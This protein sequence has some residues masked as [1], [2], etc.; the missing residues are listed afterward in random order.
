VVALVFIGP[1]VAFDRAKTWSAIANNGLWFT[2]WGGP[3]VSIGLIAGDPRMLDYVPADA[4]AIVWLRSVEAVSG[5]P[6]RDG[7][8]DELLLA[9]DHG[10]VAVVIRGDI[11]KTS[12]DERRRAAGELRKSLREGG[13]LGGD[14]ALEIREVA[15]D[16]LVMVSAGWASDLDRRI[17]GAPGPTRL[18]AMLEKAPVD[19]AI[20]AVARP[21]SEVFGFA[22]T[23]AVAWVTVRDDR[24]AVDLRVTAGDDADSDRARAQTLLDAAAAG[25]TSDCREPAKTL[26][27]A[28]RLET[29]GDV[30]IGRARFEPMD[31]FAAMF[32]KM[33]EGEGG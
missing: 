18:V 8:A 20:A 31:L 6:A 22:V 21:R 13:L 10:G 30:V 1:L 25:A 16:I 29:D 2:H 24:L 23:D 11:G 7:D 5:Q 32:C 14:E 27:S 26:V 17:A 9:L 33:A 4:E 28:I 19:V 15:S 3:E 12:S